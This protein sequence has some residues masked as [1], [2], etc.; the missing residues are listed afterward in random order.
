MLNL[1]LVFFRRQ[2]EV[3]NN[4]M[5]G[6]GL[7]KGF[8]LVELLIV[9]ALI[10]VLSVAVLSTLNPIEQ[11]NKAS[12]SSRKND[13]AEILSAVE[14]YYATQQ[15]Y[16][17]DSQDVSRSPA[18]A[19]GG[20]V[21]FGGVGICALDGGI[22]AEGDCDSDGVLLS[23]DELKSAF[24][25]KSYLRNNATYTDKIYLF[26]EADSTSGSTGNISVCFV[27]KAKSNRN[28]KS[29]LYSLTVDGNDVVTA[30]GACSEDPTWTS[31]STSCYMCVPE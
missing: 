20:N 6:K 1:S 3:Q 21:N 10:G 15:K 5:F 28:D 11:V 29:K 4:K 18:D 12:D 14:R 24:R 17:W 30:K 13:A 31:Q 16:P 8:T 26:K 2:I 9:I 27:P 22:S 23:T 19:Y 7:S 25:S